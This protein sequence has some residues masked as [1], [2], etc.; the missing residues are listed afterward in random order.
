MLTIVKI[1]TD[2]GYLNPPQPILDIEDIDD[3]ADDELCVLM[4][5]SQ[6]E[7]M[8]ALSKVAR[9]QNRFVEL[10]ENDSVIFSSTPSSRQ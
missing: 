5:G 6:G 2:L 4:T 3:Y 10:R 8:A 7:P 1:A 9:G